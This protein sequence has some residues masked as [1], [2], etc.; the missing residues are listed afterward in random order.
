MSKPLHNLITQF[1]E[2]WPL[3]GAEDWDRP[4][5]AVGN[6][7]ESIAKILLTVDVT[8][9]VLEEAKSIGATLVLAH[10]PLLLKAESLLS[11]DTLKGELVSYAISNGIAIYSAHTNAD[12]VK[13]GVSDSLAAALGLIN[14]RPL[15]ETSDGSG[16]G[17]IGKLPKPLKFRELGDLVSQVIPNTNAPI[18]LAGDLERI[19]ETVAVVGG[20]G[21]SFIPDAQ[22]QLADVLVTSDLRHHVCLD[23]ISHP[24]APLCLIDVSHFAAESLWLSVAS[25]QL[26]ALF[27]ELVFEL[28]KIKTDPWSLTIGI[29][30]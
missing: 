6:P 17:R 23:A 10:H 19:V 8:K 15:V 30:K 1:E 13:D 18:R 22:S 26:Q 7:E 24:T 20:A 5:L 25:S 29:Q 2:L 14:Y 9:Q 12:I 21:D 3:Y 4:G 11:T 27:P 16:H 28:S